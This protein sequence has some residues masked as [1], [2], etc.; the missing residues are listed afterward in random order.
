MPTNCIRFE[1]IKSRE[2]I[3]TSLLSNEDYCTRFTFQKK[4]FKSRNF[5]KNATFYKV[6]KFSKHICMDFFAISKIFDWIFVLCW[7]KIVTYLFPQTLCALTYQ[8][9]SPIKESDAMPNPLN[10]RHQAIPLAYFSRRVDP[11]KI[12]ELSRRAS[13]QEKQ[14]LLWNLRFLS[15]HHSQLTQF[16]KG[17]SSLHILKDITDKDAC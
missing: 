3:T 5:S 16:L 12:V 4:L 9:I 13:G 6:S 7:L 15:L 17:L 1:Q 11:Y 8:V 2:D 14:L 10:Y